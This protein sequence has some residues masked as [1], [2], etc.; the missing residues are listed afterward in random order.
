[1]ESRVRRVET[2]MTLLGSGS[3]PGVLEGVEPAVELIE[4]VG[5]G[6]GGPLEAFPDGGGIR[7]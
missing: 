6:G 1:M 4:L 2:P 3:G 5:G 7:N